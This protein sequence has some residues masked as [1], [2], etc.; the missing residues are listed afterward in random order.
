MLNFI[1][2]RPLTGILRS[3]QILE[4]SSSAKQKASALLAGVDQLA[5]QVG[6]AGA[7]LRPVRTKLADTAN[8]LVTTA[9][10]SASPKLHTKTHT[11]K[12]TQI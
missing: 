10:V 3:T 11:H 7:E 4:L 1:L 5:E 6:D 12:H 9:Q 8:A 2:L